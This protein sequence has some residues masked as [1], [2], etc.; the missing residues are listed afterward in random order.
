M[1]QVTFERVTKPSNWNI[2][3]GAYEPVMPPAITPEDLQ[4]WGYVAWRFFDDGE[5]MAI[6]AMT[7]GKGRLCSGINL[8]GYED[9]WCYPSIADAL[10]AMHQ[11]NPE[12][13]KEPTGWHRHPF[14]G[15]RRENCDPAKETV[16]F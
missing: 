9:C 1:T 11:F 4:A 7:Q 12:V 16:Y 13:E 2:P 14:S 15:R 10:I 6:T 5:I 3:I 8:T